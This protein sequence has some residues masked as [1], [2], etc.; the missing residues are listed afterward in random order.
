MPDSQQEDQQ[1]PDQPAF[2]DESQQQ[3]EQEHGMGYTVEG[4][5]QDRIA[6]VAAIQL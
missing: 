6:D 2:V 5:A 1:G 3:E 4:T